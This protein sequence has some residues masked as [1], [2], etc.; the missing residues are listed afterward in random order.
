MVREGRRSQRGFASYGSLH[1][2]E[3]KDLRI[4]PR[5]AP[6]E[7]R[8]GTATPCCSVS[9]GYTTTPKARRVAV[10]QLRCGLVVM[11]ID[12]GSS[13]SKGGWQRGALHAQRWDGPG[14]D[15]RT[16]DGTFT[17][18]QRGCDRLRDQDEKLKA[19]SGGLP[20]LRTLSPLPDASSRPLWGSDCALCQKQQGRGGRE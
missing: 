14:W 8:N 1:P 13:S 9:M 20:P 16:W 10:G 5:R 11:A 6:R 19:S 12:A 2:E 4:K 3:Q 18:V 15:C 17:C 7:N